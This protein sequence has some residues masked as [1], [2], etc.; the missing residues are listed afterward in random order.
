MVK[1]IFVFVLFLLLPSLLAAQPGKLQGTI[2]DNKTGTPLPGVAVIIEDCNLEATTGLDGRYFI[3]AVPP[4][5]HSVRAE[6][7]GYRQITISRVRVETNLTTTFDLRLTSA[8]SQFDSLRLVAKQPVVQHDVT[9]TFRTFTQED[10]QNLPIRGLKNIIALNAGTVVQNGEFHIRGG[11]S[12]EINFLIDGATVTN[13]F[14]NDL[15]ATVIQEAVQEIKMQTGGFTAEY[16]GANSAVVNTTIRTGGSKIRGTAD[17]RTDDFAKGGNTFLGTTSRGY[18]NVVG[19]I[20]GPVPF[21]PK[22]KFFLAGQYNYAGNRSAVFIEPFTF[23]PLDSSLPLW[24]RELWNKGQ[25]KFYAPWLMEDGLAGRADFT[26]QPLTNADGKV[27][28]FKFERNL[29]PNNNVRSFSTNGTM[30]YNW[31]NSLTLK[32]T[33]GYNFTRQP[34]SWNTFYNAVVNYYSNSE[35][36]I[37]VKQGFLNLHA[38]HRID[39]NTFYDVGLHWSTQKTKDYDA[40]FGDDWLKYTDAREWAKAGLDTSQWQSVFT[41]PLRYSTVFD[42]NLTPPNSP[43]NRWGRSNYT[44]SSQDNMGLSLDFTTQFTDDL[45]IKFGGRFDRWI[46]RSWGV[47]SAAYLNYVYGLD[48]ELWDPAK[49]NNGGRTWES[50]PVYGSAKYRKT[51]ELDRYGGI[52]Y[53]GWDLMGE[54]KIKDGPYG[55]RKPSF[56]SS[57]LQTKW[58]YKNV[59]LNLG[60]RWEHYEYNALRP[61]APAYPRYDPANEWIDVDALIYTKPYNYI[62]PRMN[63]AFLYS[64]K[65][66]LF[67]RFGKYVQSGRLNNVYQSFTSLSNLIPSRR[68]I[69]YPSIYYLQKPEQNDRYE[70]GIRKGL[71]GNFAVTATVFYK[72]MYNLIGARKLYADGTPAP[73]GEDELPKGTQFAGGYVNEDIAIAKGLELIFDLYRTKR[74]SARIFYTL[75][76]VRGSSSNMHSNDVVLSDVYT[77]RFPAYIYPL[78]YNQT[79]RGT[80]MLDYRF[81]KGDGGKFLEGFG[82]NLLFTFNSGHAYTKIREVTAFG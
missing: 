36:R 32:L 65:T 56:A 8:G 39:S 75:S 28:P 54:K 58:E 25:R 16:G 82:F 76:H 72:N 18:H 37:D 24:S 78:N 44:K 22:I 26:G 13:P 51:L 10:I 27:I 50:D 42:F 64:Q 43:R 80:V 17:Y 47:N 9:N 68:N 49:P 48:A 4:G 62:L 70:L 29:L 31:T 20:G 77:A 53:Y 55:P 60:L 5:L 15:S 23:D 1:K 69:L 34:Q 35:R 38:T 6:F 66:V 79:H 2:V 45:E 7:A 33:G 19:T 81:T 46:A 67:A 57:Y 61:E 41:G 3:L 71:S 21:F 14:A 59:T 73:A 74:M 52:D 12:R 40:R 11:R 63:L 30:V